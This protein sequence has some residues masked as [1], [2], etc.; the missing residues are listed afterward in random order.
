MYRKAIA[1]IL[2]ACAAFLDSHGQLE[3]STRSTV[4]DYY[5]EEFLSPAWEKNIITADGPDFS[6]LR[7]RSGSLVAKQEAVAESIAVSNL[8]QIALA[9]N[10][11]FQSGIT[12]LVSATNGMPRSGMTIGLVI[13]LEISEQR[14][15]IEGFIAAQ[16]YNR[17][18]NTD[19]LTIHFTRSL[20]VQPKIA[21]PYITDGGM[22]TNTIEGTFRNTNFSGSNWTNVYTVTVGET[23]YENCHKLY[24]TRPLSMYDATVWFNTNVRWGTNDGIEYGIIVHTAYGEPLFSGTLTNYVDRTYVVIKDG[25]IMNPGFI[26]YASAEQQTE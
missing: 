26:S 3:S 18:F 8:T 9:Y 7:D 20:A 4:Y 12:N 10:N 11:G 2:V 1:T 5:S 13:P 14:T 6:N 19:I 25:A 15:A 24:V 22:T 16:E 23:T 17:E 21:C